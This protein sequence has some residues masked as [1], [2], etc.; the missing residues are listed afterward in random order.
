MRGRVT[1]CTTIAEQSKTGSQRVEGG[2]ALFAEIA[3]AC[4]DVLWS[5][6][7]GFNTR[8]AMTLHARES[9]LDLVSI[10]GAQVVT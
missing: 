1:D 9:L 6:A 2:N 4:N 7:V 5:N 10:I 8:H 3:H